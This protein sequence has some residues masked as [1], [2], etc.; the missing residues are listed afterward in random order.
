MV[1]HNTF[2]EEI[3]SCY[4]KERLEEMFPFFSPDE[5]ASE[6]LGVIIFHTSNC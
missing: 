4:C 5:N 3:G 2:T 6:E 1:P